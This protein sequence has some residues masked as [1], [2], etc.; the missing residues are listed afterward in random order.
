MGAADSDTISIV[1][2]MWLRSPGYLRIAVCDIPDGG[3]DMA[4][5]KVDR[6]ISHWLT[7]S[8]VSALGRFFFLSDIYIF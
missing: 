6:A 4:V 8:V 1:L 2:G 3:T 7:S 5:S